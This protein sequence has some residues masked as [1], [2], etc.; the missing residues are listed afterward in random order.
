MVTNDQNL[1]ICVGLGVAILILVAYQVNVNRKQQTEIENIKVKTDSLEEHM[2]VLADA[3]RGNLEKTTRLQ[4]EL[5]YNYN[6]QNNKK[7]AKRGKKKKTVVESDVD[8][9]TAALG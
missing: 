6:S 8:L 2:K 5:S 1:Y 9:V 4:T 3:V 7:S